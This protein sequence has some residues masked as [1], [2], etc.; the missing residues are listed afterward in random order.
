[1]KHVVQRFQEALLTH[2]EVDDN[3]F[4]RK[5][6]VL[7]GLKGMNRMVMQYE[8]Q[9]RLF[10]RNYDLIFSFAAPC[11]VQFQNE[12]MELRLHYEGRI[13]VQG[14]RFVCKKG[15]SEAFLKKLNHKLLAERLAMLDFLDCMLVHREGAAE[16]EITV[17]SLIGS[18]VWN[19]IPPVF[20]VI[21]P[22][23]NECIRMMESFELIVHG[24]S[25]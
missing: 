20:Q 12:A 25:A 11:P 23:K 7:H 4:L 5:E 15:N 8:L 10:A 9:D 24:L 22:K 13:S 6:V 18:A 2:F 21:E 17:R 1:M 14:A 3:G 16:W 19:L